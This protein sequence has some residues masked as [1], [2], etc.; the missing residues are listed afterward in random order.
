MTHLRTYM[1]D[2]ASLSLFDQALNASLSHKK[3]AFDI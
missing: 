2:R 1:N 3:Q